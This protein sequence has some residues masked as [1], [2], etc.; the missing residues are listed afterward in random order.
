MIFLH[1][2]SVE[3]LKPAVQAFDKERRKYIHCAGIVMATV[4]FQA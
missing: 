4:I 2:T 3:G 1:C